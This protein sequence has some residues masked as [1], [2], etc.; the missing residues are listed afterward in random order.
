MWIRPREVAQGDLSK[1][2]LLWRQLKHPN[3]LPFLGINTELFS[4]SYCIISPWM[5]NGDIMSYA[6]Q[7]SLGIDTKLRYTM[8]IVEAIAYLHG[9]DPPVVHGDIK[10]ANIM[11]SDDHSCCLA[12]F[13]LSILD[14]PSINPTQT[15]TVQGSLRWLAPE[16]INPTSSSPPRQGTLTSRD[17]YAF[18]CT[19]CELLTGKPPF[20]HHTLD[21]SVAIDVLNGVRP[22]L[23]VDAV[24][25]ETVFNAICGLLDLCWSEQIM[26]RPDA[27][28]LLESLRHIQ[29]H[30]PEAKLDTHCSPM[31]SEGDTSGS[32]LP[33]GEDPQLDMDLPNN[34]AAFSPLAAPLIDWN[35]LTPMSSPRPARRFLDFEV[36]VSPEQ[37][38]TSDASG[39]HANYDENRAS[40]SNKRKSEDDS[41][42]PPPEKIPRWSKLT[43]DS[44]F[45]KDDQHNRR[46]FQSAAGRS[47]LPL[48]RQD[49]FGV[50]LKSPIKQKI[51]EPPQIQN[52]TP[53][54]NPSPSLHSDPASVRGLPVPPSEPKSRPALKLQRRGRRL[55][56]PSEDIAPPSSSEPKSSPAS[57]LPRRG[58]RAV[59]PWEDIMPPS[60][61]KPDTSPVVNV[62]PQR[63]PR[64]KGSPRRKAGMISSTRKEHIRG[65]EERDRERERE[66][67]IDSG[68]SMAVEQET[69]AEMHVQ[70]LGLLWDDPKLRQAWDGYLFRRAI[71][72]HFSVDAP[73][74]VGRMVGQGQK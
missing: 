64:K 46:T 20:S 31:L 7:L 67:V 14:T 37:N 72:S 68:T 57:K 48:P 50:A 61:S 27:D 43:Q 38:S 47:Q 40:G 2:V 29:D 26:K 32:T 35:N 10:G 62:K 65:T 19:V 34:V 30:Y 1:E 4:P 54:F 69:S 39:S 18:G 36:A 66:R 9:L 52:D 17:I 21:I 74:G 16:F 42:N 60:S 49:D 6:R 55:V 71:D 58:R 73:P 70:R 11:I 15:T 5:S 56:M 45:D 44:D 33:N 63:R 23:P 41:E 51:D 12:D 59:S 13:G 8:Q 3:I 24:L 28:S 22:V 53:V 25:N